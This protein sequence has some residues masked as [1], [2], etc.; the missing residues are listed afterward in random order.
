ME[1]YVYVLL[2]PF[3]NGIFTYDEY[4][5]EYEPFYVGKGKGKRKTNTISEKKNIF[6]KRVIEKI[7]NYE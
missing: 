3:K 7:K 2:D 6:K 5:F 1:F 4:H